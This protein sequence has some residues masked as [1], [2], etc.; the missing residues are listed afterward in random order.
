M[1]EP[2]RRDLV[3]PGTALGDRLAEKIEPLV[4]VDAQARERP[5]VD[6]QQRGGHSSISSCSGSIAASTAWSSLSDRP[7]SRAASQAVRLGL[8]ERSPRS[9][10]G[11]PPGPA[12]PPAAP[13]G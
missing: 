10:F 2:C 7:L 3:N 9:P 13:Q 1:A 8:G 4:P 12:G 6:R 11:A 5:P